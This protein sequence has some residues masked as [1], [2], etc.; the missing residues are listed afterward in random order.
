LGRRNFSRGKLNSQK[1]AY[2]HKSVRRIEQPVDWIRKCG[3]FSVG[4]FGGLVGGELLPL[5]VINR[6]F[7]SS[8]YCDVL[9]QL[10]WPILQERFEN[11]PF[12]YIQDNAPAHK[13]LMVREWTEESAPELYRAMWQLPPYSP[14]LNPTEHVWATLKQKL[15]LRGNFS[16]PL[17]LTAAVLEIWNEIGQN[18]AY[19]QGLCNS[20][21]RR[22]SAV[23]AAEGAPTDY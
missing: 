7:D 16:S 4:F 19:L 8:Q 15:K 2:V 20:M 3:K 1:K 21:P 22:L 10:Y 6:G 12:R 11:R 5:Y 23:I 13:S 14:D 17:E 9:E 18:R